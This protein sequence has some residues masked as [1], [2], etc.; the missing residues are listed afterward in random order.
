MLTLRD[1]LLLPAFDLRLVGRSAAEVGILY[2]AAAFLTCYSP[3]AL[4]AAP[5]TGGGPIDPIRVPHRPQ[6]F[7][8]GSTTRR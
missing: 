4:A 6:L 3:P 1:Q 8:S 7:C 2:A 5:H